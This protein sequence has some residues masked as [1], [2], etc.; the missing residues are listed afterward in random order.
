MKKIIHTRKIFTLDM[1]QKMVQDILSFWNIDLQQNINV[2]AIENI[3][4][5]N[6]KINLKNVYTI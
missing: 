5:K 2:M 3:S 1:I 4:K 6:R